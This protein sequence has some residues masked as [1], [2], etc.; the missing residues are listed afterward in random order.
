M[1]AT[2]DHTHEEAKNIRTFW[3]KTEK[4]VRYTAGQ[5]TQ[6]KLPHKHPDDRGQKRWF[7]VSA[8]PTDDM[9]SITTKFAGGKASSFKKALFS[10]P[11]GT[12]VNLDDPMGDFVLPK[13]KDRPLIF[14]AGGIGVTPM[15]SMI[16]WLVD[17]D[18]KRNIYLL[19]AANKLEDVAFRD[20]F[21]QAPITFDILLKDPPKG[22]QGKVGELTA[23]LILSLPGA[24]DKAL[25]YLSG[26][27]PMIEKFYKELKEKGVDQRRLVTD[28][29]PGYTSI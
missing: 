19:Y 5:Y 13:Q 22:W 18:E 4:P 16:K 20:L 9:L 21:E 2:L 15:H 17:Q 24:T 23:D 12:Q 3:F 8:S 1:K 14:V 29:F 6:L 26:P 11:M 27:E 10:L 28:D 7:T 25:I